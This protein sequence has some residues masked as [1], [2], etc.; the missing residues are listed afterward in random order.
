MRNLLIFSVWLAFLSATS[1]HAQRSLSFTNFTT[2]NGLPDNYVCGGVAIGSDNVKWF[3]TAD[4]VAK[5]SNNTWTVYKS[6]QG[7]VSNYTNC[8][9]VDNQNNL[10]VGTDLGVSKFDGTTWTTFTTADG[11]I[12]NAIVSIAVA[13]DNAVWFA[14]YAGVSKLSA[15]TWTSFTTTQG[16]PTNAINTIAFD[17]NGNTWLG[18]MME[19]VAKIS[20]GTVT[21]LNTSNGLPDNNV[22]AIAI[23]AQNNKWVGTWYGL[24]KFDTNDNF[25]ITYT[26]ETG[27]HNDFIRSLA[28][29]S[30]QKLWIGMFADYNLDGGVTLFDGQNWT[31]FTIEDGLADTQVI[32]LDID[33]DNNVWIATGNGVS[34]LHGEVGIAN[35][36]SISDLHLF[37]NPSSDFLMVDSE[38]FPSLVTILNMNGVEVLK[39]NLTQQQPITI[40]DLPQGLYLFRMESAFDSKSALFYKK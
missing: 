19:G 38:T 16:L 25:V 33:S 13:P 37:P 30:D 6:E 7:L 18:T 29:D 12:D 35:S 3:G 28:F 9:A 4:G 21:V 17:A 14:T 36:N 10:W 32:G 1:V 27:L 2:A 8:V 20:N 39:Q 23:D 24:T 26:Y 22:F 15:D 34:F 11:L 5:F 31:S 40:Q